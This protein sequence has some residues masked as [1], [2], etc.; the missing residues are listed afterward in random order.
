M[1]NTHAMRLWPVLGWCTN[2]LCWCPVFT[3]TENVMLGDE[4]LLPGGLLD[5]K[6]AAAKIAEISE[7]YNLDVDPTAYVKDLPVG[8]QQRVEIIKLLY[9]KCRYINFG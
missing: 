2:I 5:R 9:Q 3:V 4:D 1:S 6:K 7:K 8:I